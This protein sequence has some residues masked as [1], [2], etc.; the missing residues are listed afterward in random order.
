MPARSTSLPRVGPRIGR[1]PQSVSVM[2][3][4]PLD[5]MTWLPLPRRRRL[6]ISNPNLRKA[7]TASPNGTLL[8][9]TGIQIDQHAGR[10]HRVALGRPVLFHLL[11]VFGFL[12]SR[13]PD[14]LQK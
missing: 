7:D 8:I 3:I 12:H 13:T 9:D 14:F 1:L 10:L 11:G 5:N 6:I 4:C 2:L